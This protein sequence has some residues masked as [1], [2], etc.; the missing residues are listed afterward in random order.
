MKLSKALKKAKNLLLE[1]GWIQGLH[2]T[3]EG[4][5]AI[6]ALA[7]VTGAVFYSTNIDGTY[8][9]EVDV[10]NETFFEASR[11]LGWAIWADEVAYTIVELFEA[12]DSPEMTFE[13]MLCY[14]DIAI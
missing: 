7:E 2:R 1:E 14:F 6:G 11:Y 10:D 5:C 3:D 12:N 13:L 9:V 8:S 4:Y